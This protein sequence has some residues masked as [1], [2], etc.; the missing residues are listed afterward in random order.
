MCMVATIALG[1]N[2]GNKEFKEKN[3]EGLFLNH[4]ILPFPFCD[5]DAGKVVIS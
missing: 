4:D 3:K 2:K 5:D 1:L